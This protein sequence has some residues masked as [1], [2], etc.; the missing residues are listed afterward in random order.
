MQSC[1]YWG[2]VR[3]RR[4]RPVEHTFRYRLFHVLLDLR[5][6]DTVFQG[7]WLWSSRR[8]APARFRRE[9]HFGDPAQPLADAVRDLVAQ[10]TGVRPQGPI[11]LLTH[12]RYFGVAM[13]PVSFYFCQTRA[14][15]LEALVLEVH[16]TPW[17]EHHCYVAARPHGTRGNVR[18]YRFPK[19][20]H[21]S[22]FMTLDQ[23]YRC[24]VRSPGAHCS[25]HLENW[26]AG[27]KLFDATLTLRRAPITT[28]SLAWSLL[29]YP[30]MTVQVL[31]AIYFEALRLWWKGCP[32]VPH[33]GRAAVPAEVPYHE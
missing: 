21:V 7:R 13:N 14:G 8:T 15:A 22:P 24:T 30:F 32:Y 25:V 31:G 5:E 3:H 9:D 19:C 26:R 10:H 1:L 18:E 2:Q 12:L 16:N 23:E 11:Q 29:A 33:P 6:V 27:E 17:G 4:F 28:G 20:F